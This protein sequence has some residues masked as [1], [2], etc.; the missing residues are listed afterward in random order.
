[1][2]PSFIRRLWFLGRYTCH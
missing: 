2:T 1:L